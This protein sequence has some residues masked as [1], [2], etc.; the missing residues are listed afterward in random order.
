MPIPTS[1]FA[2]HP[3]NS[4]TGKYCG[5][6]RDNKVRCDHDAPYE[7]LVSHV[8]GTGDGN[9]ARFSIK[10]QK[11]DFCADT[12]DG[13]V[14][15]RKHLRLWEKFSIAQRVNS[16]QLQG[17]RLGGNEGWC[18]YHDGSFKC[19][20]PFSFAD[21]RFRDSF[22]VPIVPEEGA[23]ALT[24]C[25]AFRSANGCLSPTSKNIECQGPHRCPYAGCVDGDASLESPEPVP[26]APAVGANTT[27]P[28]P[29]APESVPLVPPL[30]LQP[31]PLPPAMGTGP[32][33]PGPLPP[34]PMLPPPPPPQ[35]VLGPVEVAPLSPFSGEGGGGVP[36]GAPPLVPCTDHS[37]RLNPASNFQ[38]YRRCPPD[39]YMA[40]IYVG[41]DTQRHVNVALTCCPFQ[42]PI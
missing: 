39:N 19:D 26:V 7:F 11:G 37:F 35:P 27:V 24:G 8:P 30:A 9:D 31:V 16:V 18:G 25:R 33:P 2:F 5:P 20:I 15:D 3:R 29:V 40:G 38:N 10:D 23:C 36:G 14:C 21:P 6:G 12:P 34:T 41:T 28:P 32:P 22:L 4:D 13:V 1:G 17:S 42:R